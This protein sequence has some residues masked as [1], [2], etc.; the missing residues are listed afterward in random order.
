MHQVRRKKSLR[1][2]QLDQIRL[3][4]VLRPASV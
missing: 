3:R 1:R 4:Q 2:E